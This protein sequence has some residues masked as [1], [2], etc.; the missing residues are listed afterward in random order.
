[1]RPGGSPMAHLAQS[2][3]DAGLYDARRPRR[4]AT[5]RPRW[6]QPQWLIEAVRQSKVAAGAQLLLV[7]DQFRGT[8]PVQ[9]DQRGQPGESVQFVN[10]LLHATQQADQNV[11]IVLTMRSDFL[12]ECS[13]FLGLAEAVNDGEFLIPKM[14]RDQ[15]QEAIQAPSACAALKS[16]AP[17][18]PVAQRCRG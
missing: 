3:C 15:I 8:L 16:P 13:G 11:F 7:V 10:L 6:S 17:A 5:F 14:T 12:G 2:L 1:M 18:L 4:L 9:P